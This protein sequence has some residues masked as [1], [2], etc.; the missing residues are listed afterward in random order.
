[1]DTAHNNLLSSPLRD[2]E[3]IKICRELVRTKKY[4]EA[5]SSLT[6]LEHPGHPDA[7]V[8]RGL[9]ARGL[10]NITLERFYL[11]SA[12]AMAPDH[13]DVLFHLALS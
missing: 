2:I 7:L 12:I 11:E 1:M 13:A 3:L 6:Q 8:L 9:V 10:G 4:I 5:L